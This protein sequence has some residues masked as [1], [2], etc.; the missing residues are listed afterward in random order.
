M[1]LCVS[2]LCCISA[3][4]SL[5]VEEVQQISLPFEGEGEGRSDLDLEGREAHLDYLERG[6]RKC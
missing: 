5:C 6:G 2:T 4:H 3:I 1:Y